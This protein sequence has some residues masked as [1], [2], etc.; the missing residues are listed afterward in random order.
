MEFSDKTYTWL[1]GLSSCPFCA[2]SRQYLKAYAGAS[3]VRNRSGRQ[4]SYRWGGVG[5]AVEPTRETDGQ[6]PILPGKNRNRMRKNRNRS[7]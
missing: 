7:I 1:W 6:K 5:C 3:I 4:Y 2:S